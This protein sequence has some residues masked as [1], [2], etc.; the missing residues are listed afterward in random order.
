MISSPERPL[1]TCLGCRTTRNK[2]ELLRVFRNGEGRIQADPAGKAGGRGAYLCP[3]MTC[4][5][6]V[7]KSGALLRTLKG[8]APDHLYGDLEELIAHFPR[9][10]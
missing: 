7:K 1:R 4:L 5:M 3:D 2:R 9:K 6:R 8:E 10:P